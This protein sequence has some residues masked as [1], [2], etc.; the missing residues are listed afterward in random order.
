MWATNSATC[1]KTATP[2]AVA[3]ASQPHVTIP[4]LFLITVF[5]Y[6][7]N[8]SDSQAA[9]AVLNR[10]DWKYALHL[11]LISLGFDQIE[12][13]EYHRKLLADPMVLQLPERP[14]G[15]G[16]QPLRIAPAKTPRNVDTASMLDAVHTLNRFSQMVRA[17]RLALDELAIYYPDWLKKTVLPHWFHRYSRSGTGCGSPRDLGEAGGAR[18]GGGRGRVLSSGRPGEGGRA[19]RGLQPAR[20]RVFSPRLEPAVRQDCGKGHLE[21]LP[22]ASR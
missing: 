7:E 22:G 6:L 2:D 16:P 15:T 5:Q 20:G 19:P 11:P 21:N 9:A 8:M 17:M 3:D 1:A 13:D 4:L 14:A 10:V 12:L 18:A